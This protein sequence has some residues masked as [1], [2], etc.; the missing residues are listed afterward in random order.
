MA[1]QNGRHVGEQSLN[2]LQPLVNREILRLLL[3][4]HCRILSDHMRG[5]T[6]ARFLRVS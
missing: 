2:P 3:A 5:F 1:A 6:Y 4:I